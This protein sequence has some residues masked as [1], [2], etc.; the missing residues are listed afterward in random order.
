MMPMLRDRNA[1]MRKML[2]EDYGIMSN[3][4]L[5][6]AIYEMKR[7]NLAIMLAPFGKENDETT[8]SEQ[9]NTYT[10]REQAARHGK[11]DNLCY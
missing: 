9:F 8:E 10:G 6:R 1:K 3:E 2:A 7:A 11:G 4:E 5:A